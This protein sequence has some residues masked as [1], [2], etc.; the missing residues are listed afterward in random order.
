MVIVKQR[1]R[2]AEKIAVEA[3]AAPKVMVL[4]LILLTFTSTGVRIVHARQI[5]CILFKIL[6]QVPSLN[7]W[8]RLARRKLQRESASI[9]II[10]FITVSQQLKYI[11][12]LCL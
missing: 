3:M 11:M 2:A 7:H 12:Y 5:I 10:M 1:V 4:R 8:T 9:I 6:Y